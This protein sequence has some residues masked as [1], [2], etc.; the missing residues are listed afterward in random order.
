MERTATPDEARSALDTIERRRRRVIDEIDM[1]G[2]YWWGLSLGWIA[3]GFIND[4]DNAWVGAVATL[5]FGAAHASVAPRVIEA[6]A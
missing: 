3:L 4:L 2:W 6:G 5:I 1:P